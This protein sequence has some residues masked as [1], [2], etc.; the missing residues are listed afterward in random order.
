MSLRPEPVGPVPEETARVARAAFPKGNVYLRL[1]DA[2]GGLYEDA[3]FAPLFAA[4]GRPAERPWRL[5][6]VTV[7]QFAEGLSDRQAAEAVRARIDWKYAL[8]LELT[9]PGF[10]YSVLCAFRARL[11]AGGAAQ[12]LFDALL[13]VC[14]EHGYLKARGRQ[15][16]DSTHVLGALRGLNRLEL[17]AETLRAALNA[18]AAADPDWL[19][20]RAP[21]AW[22]ER[23]SR[24]IED[25]RFPKG[26]VARAAYAELVGEDGMHL[27]REVNAPTAPPGL[28]SLAAVEGLRRTWVGHYAVVDGAARLRAPKDM[29]PTPTQ[30]QSPYEA[31]ARY[32]Y[33][34]GSTWR[35]YKVH[36]TETCDDAGPHLLTHVATT[37][38]T[39]ADVAQLAPIQQGLAQVGLEPAQQFVDTA[40]LCASNLLTSRA[41]HQIELIGPVF[42]DHQWQAR[43]GTG[44]DVAHF[45]V[46]W[47]RH[48]VTC[49]EGR[50]SAGW[51]PSHTS[52]GQ[53]IIR[54]AFAPADCF[55][56]PARAQCTRAKGQP[57]GLTL[58]AQAEHEAVHAARRWQ[59]TDAF[60]VLYAR[61]AGIEGTISQG[62][63]AFGLRRARYRGL[64]KT[65][66]QHLAT[67][68]ALN[69]A[70][71]AAWLG[72]RTPEATRR[73]RFAAL[74]LAA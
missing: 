52:G 66:L 10:D 38:A 26:E 55:A 30:R 29:A 25:Y 3:T 73:S 11:V 8:G 67:A 22:F 39:A 18:V 40:Y 16:T 14:R 15:R 36:L 42:V 23:Y 9:D 74:A 53:P 20:A 68:A 48:V 2:L 44:Y 72:G 51:Y 71:L 33:K 27:L 62:V 19:R 12:Q 57:R 58:Q 60:A 32:G 46:D 61:R 5:A 4:R 69:L 34:R 37:V 56:C 41:H 54:V 28:R 70:R 63:R 6:L 64:P 1:R 35:G 43:A 50:Q 24:R 17:L 49:P 31:D 47:A 21:A 13:A 7:L 59:A 65:H 45:R